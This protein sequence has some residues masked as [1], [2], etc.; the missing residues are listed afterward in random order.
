MINLDAE[1][2]TQELKDRGYAVWMNTKL[3]CRPRQ[4]YGEVAVY[5]K[6]IQ[7]KGNCEHERPYIQAVFLELPDGTGALSAITAAT[8]EDAK[9]AK[10]EECYVKMYSNYSEMHG[11]PL[12]E[13]TIEQIRYANK[14]RAK[15]HM[16]HGELVVKAIN[17]I[18]ESGWWLDNSKRTHH[19]KIWKEVNALTDEQIKELNN[20]AKA[21]R[22]VY[23]EARFRRALREDA[24]KN[25]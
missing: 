14:I 15:A 21:Q 22:E 13:G 11:F 25:K 12:F 3:V 4:E 7:V 24:R 16:K 17:N 23:E 9:K 18:T 5:T 8:I 6:V 19:A 2:I 10:C 20:E 1:D